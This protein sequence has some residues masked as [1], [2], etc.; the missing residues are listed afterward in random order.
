MGPYKPI[1]YSLFKCEVFSPDGM[2]IQTAG[3]NKNLDFYASSLVPGQKYYLA[4]SYGDILMECIEFASETCERVVYISPAHIIHNCGV[5]VP[6]RTF[7]NSVKGKVKKRFEYNVPLMRWAKNALDV[8][9]AS[10]HESSSRK[11]HKT[12]HALD[13]F[14]ES[15]HEGAKRL[16]CSSEVIAFKAGAALAKSV[17]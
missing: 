2:L 15:T 1:D 11:R 14:I 3:I 4:F 6:P 16:S 7:I 10:T 13:A 5:T 17:K 12:K 8:F 9:I